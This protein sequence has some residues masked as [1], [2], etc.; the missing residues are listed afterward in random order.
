MLLIVLVFLGACA[1]AG[2]QPAWARQDSPDE[3]IWVPTPQGLHHVLSGFTC[4]ASLGDWTFRSVTMSAYPVTGLNSGC[5]LNGPN[6]S[7][8]SFFMVHNTQTP[9][10]TDHFEQTRYA[11]QTVA[12]TGTERPVPVRSDGQPVAA[13]AAAARATPYDGKVRLDKDLQD[14]ALWMEEVGGWHMYVRAT[15]Y[16]GDEAMVADTAAALF[17]SARAGYATALMPF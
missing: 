12:S 17:E 10:L 13:L 11:M 15:Y 14:T 4:P 9:P 8:I 3:K 16:R 2:V 6:R 1:V 7:G 5:L